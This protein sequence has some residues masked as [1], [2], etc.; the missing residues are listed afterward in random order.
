MSADPNFRN[1][2]GEFDR[3]LFDSALR[4]WT[5]RTRLRLGNAQADLRQFIVAALTDGHSAPKAEVKAEAD[6]EA[7]T[8]AVDYFLLPASAAGEIPAPSDDAFKAFYNDR[9]SST[10]R[11]NIAR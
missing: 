5:S 3:A 11:P 1:E 10:A 7:Q 8:R 4:D 9:K 6:Y 2:T